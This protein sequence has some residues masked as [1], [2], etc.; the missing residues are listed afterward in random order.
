MLFRSNYAGFVQN[1][2][3]QIEIPHPTL[4]KILETIP[5]LRAEFGQFSGE[6][7]YEAPDGSVSTH[8][9]IRGHYFDSVAAQDVNGWSDEEREE[10]E[11]YLIKLA[12]RIPDY[13]QVMS[14]PPATMPWPT[15]D[16]TPAKDIPVLAKTL[17]LVEQ[18][19]KYEVENE[20]RQDVLKAMRGMLEPEAAPESEELAV[21]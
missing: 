8:A 12:A 19:L 18:A 16:E 20:Q 14:Q 3:H 4:P 9:E 13:V 11:Q 1:V 15:Y 5:A 6:Y 7:T 10:V 21:A 2:R 17:G